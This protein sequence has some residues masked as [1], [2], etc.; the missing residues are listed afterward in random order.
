MERRLKVYVYP[1]GEVPITHDGPCKN[2][3]TIEGRFIHEMERGAGGFRTGDPGPAQVYFMP[4]SV[5]WMVKYLY[6]D[7]SYDQRPL[8]VFVG[9]YVRVVSLKYPFWNLTSGADHFMLACHDWVCP[10]LLFF[11]FFFLILPFHGK[12][13]YLFMF[14]FF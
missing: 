4:F 14:F 11:S 13:T 6:K 5:A 3:Y 9:D 12:S 8:R 10:L 7:G 2:I 1:E